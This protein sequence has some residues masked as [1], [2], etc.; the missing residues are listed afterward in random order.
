MEEKSE[1]SCHPQTCSKMLRKLAQLESCRGCRSRGPSAQ[2]S[3]ARKESAQEQ[4]TSD[5]VC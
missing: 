4:S 5:T 1:W 3:S 2:E